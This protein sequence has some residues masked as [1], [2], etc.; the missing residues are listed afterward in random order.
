MYSSYKKIALF[1]LFTALMLV[2]VSSFHVYSHET[3]KNN[4]IENCSICDIVSLNQQNQFL[5]SQEI[6]APSA[7]LVFVPFER[8]FKLASRIT[9][10]G[11]IFY[12]YCRPPPVVA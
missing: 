3:D 8:N 5:V 10:D 4:K 12:F 11:N 9:L 6:N 1:F 2:K 7:N